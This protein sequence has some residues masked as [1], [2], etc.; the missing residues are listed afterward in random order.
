MTNDP[1]LASLSGITLAQPLQ[2]LRLDLMNV[3][4][5]Q[6]PI[7]NSAHDVQLLSSTIPT[8]DTFMSNVTSLVTLD[9][10]GVNLNNLNGL[11]ALTAVT[12]DFIVDQN[13]SLCSAPLPQDI[14]NQLTAPPAGTVTT[15]PNCTG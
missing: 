7:A 4:S 2:A 9:L 10:E 15:T 14:L 13:L 6:F 1:Q 5:I 11:A 3:T 8:L 12:T